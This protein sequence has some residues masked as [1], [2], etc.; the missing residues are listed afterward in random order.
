MQL[1]ACVESAD[2]QE[3]KSFRGH[4]SS[5]NGASGALGVSAGTGCVKQHGAVHNSWQRSGPNSNGAV[6][7]VLWR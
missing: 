7:G 4:G 2:S 3:S 5:R 6:G 1:N